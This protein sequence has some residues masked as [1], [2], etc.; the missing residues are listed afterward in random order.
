M[1]SAS[2]PRASEGKGG[3]AGT[4]ATRSPQGEYGEDP[5][6]AQSEHGGTLQV[7]GPR[8]TLQIK[9]FR[10]QGCLWGIVSEIIHA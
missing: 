5:P 7:I 6:L 1:P 3:E 8:V 10:R 4:G 2:L 9:R